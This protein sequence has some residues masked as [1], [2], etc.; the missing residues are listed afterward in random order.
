MIRKGP[1]PQI[2]PT[3][4]ISKATG[5]RPKAQ[6]S[7]GQ[8]RKEF[9]CFVDVFQPRMVSNR[10]K[11]SRTL[12]LGLEGIEEQMNRV[13]EVCT[14]V[15][16]PRGD[17]TGYSTLRS[18]PVADMPLWLSDRSRGE[19]AHCHAMRMH[20]SQLRRI[21]NHSE[22]L[23][24]LSITCTPQGMIRLY[25]SIGFGFGTTPRGR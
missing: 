22:S 10:G 5:R 21:Y 13:E 4:Q 8:C 11:S 16:M 1:E 9:G 23:R 3:A 12:R 7:E 14:V 24:Q 6:K 2:E 19:W 25:Q 15:T 17:E 20:A 18:V